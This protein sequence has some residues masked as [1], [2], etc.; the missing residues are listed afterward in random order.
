M[1]FSLI[2]GLIFGLISALAGLLSVNEP[3][4]AGWEFLWITTGIGG[5]VAGLLIPK[6]L[7]VKPN[8]YTNARLMTSGFIIGIL[9]HWIHWYV[10]LVAN[11]INVELFGAQMF[12]EPT[13][14][15]EA[16]LASVQLSLVSLLFFGWTAIPISI[17]TLFLTKR[18]KTEGSM[19]N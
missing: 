19:S 18:I 15:L 10:S 5:F 13:N 8:N 3:H 2:N 12:G 16:V 6:I 1:S 14:P 4:G 17:G 11:Y 9:S 7:I